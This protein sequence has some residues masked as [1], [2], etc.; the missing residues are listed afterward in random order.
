M[1][2]LRKRLRVLDA[3]CGEGGAG[4]GYWRGLT[5]LG[6]MVEV[7]GVD[8][9]AS[10]LARYPFTTVQAD[11]LEYTAAY[12]AG[13]DLIHGSPTCTGYSR[14]TAAIPDRLQ[15]Y[16]RLIP[17]FRDVAE[18]AGRPYVI[19]NVADARRELRAPLLLC[20]RMFGL[21]A[22]DDDGTPLVL[23]RH[24]LFELSA[25]VRP[26][27]HDPHDRSLQVAGS[28]AGARRDKDEARH[29]RK[30]GYVPSARVQRELLGVPWMSE[31]G[32][33]LSIPPAYTEWIARA[34]FGYVKP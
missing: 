8:T 7:V 5:D 2:L 1:N 11:A 22:T 31:R 14:G 9:V 17:V 13:F 26:P 34:L 12:G 4:M 6:F 15:R 27:V 3:F 10:R 28:Y 30:G 29:I 32:C 23:D 20:G 21:K 33:Q 16:D 24:R 25:E 19:E 18:A